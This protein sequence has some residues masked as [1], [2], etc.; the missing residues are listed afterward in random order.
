M[1]KRRQSR[2]PPPRPWVVIVTCLFAFTVVVTMMI[3]INVTGLGKSTVENFM[4][5][6]ICAGLLFGYISVSSY[7]FARRWKREEAELKAA[8]DAG[9]KKQ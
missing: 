3:V 1:A 5:V 6:V 2:R 7:R 8:D 4:I 9:T